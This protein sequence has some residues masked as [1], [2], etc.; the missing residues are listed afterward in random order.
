[1]SR[2]PRRGD[3]ANRSIE[4]HWFVKPRSVSITT[5]VLDGL[6][7][8]KELPID[9]DRS[10]SLFI[11]KYIENRDPR[12]LI[13]MCLP[14]V[15]ASLLRFSYYSVGQELIKHNVI[16]VKRFLYPDSIRPLFRSSA[17]SKVAPHP[18]CDSVNSRQSD[19]LT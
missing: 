13:V 7:T 1:M 2:A 14:K 8:L 16:I 17:R 9:N 4:N 11:L 5:I 10:V 15:C 6:T 18:P 19:S 3:F 12:A